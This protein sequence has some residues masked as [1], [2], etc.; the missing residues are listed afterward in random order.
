[1]PNDITS[2]ISTVGI[3]LKTGLLR[4][5]NEASEAYKNGDVVKTM[6][7]LKT[8]DP[9]ASDLGAEI[10]SIQSMMHNGIIHEKP[11]ELVFLVSDTDDGILTGS[12]LVSYYKSRYGIDKVTYQIC[13]GLRDDDVVRFRGEGLRNLVRNL[14][15]HVRKNPQGTTAINATGGYKAQI[16]FAGVAGQVMKVPV[17]YKHESF[18]EII[19]LPPLPVSF[20]MELWLENIEDF[21]HLAMHDM[22]PVTEVEQLVAREESA[23][24]IDVQEIDG[25]EVAALTPAGQIFHEGFVQRFHLSRNSLLPPA[26]ALT[27]DKKQF[28][29][30]PGAPTD[31]PPGIQ[32]AVDRFLSHPC[33]TGAHS[34]YYNPDLPLRNRLMPDTRSVPDGITLVY[35]DGKATSK[36][37]L[38]T[39]AVTPEQRSALIV[40]LAALLP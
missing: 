18:G 36:V 17:Y 28:R 24:L 31:R 10:T 2:L 25:R 14:A 4:L 27:P 15:Q 20:D 8:L 3:S 33:V 9:D 12:I 5:Q 38:T 23:S 29:E 37:C 32:L 7:Y 19:A 30:E 11:A 6:Q 1:M 34:W 40:E 16:L 21:M 22:V 35:S 39:T 13:T 26:S